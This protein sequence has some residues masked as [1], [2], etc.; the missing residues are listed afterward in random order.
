MSSRTLTT[1][2]GQNLERAGNPSGIHCVRGM[3]RR[4]KMQP[5]KC[6]R[7]GQIRLA[8]RPGA[9]LAGVDLKHHVPGKIELREVLQHP[10]SLLVTTSRYEM[11]IL[12]RPGPISEMDMPQ[13]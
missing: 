1:T 4:S 6:Q 11:L 7:L 12:D 5:R 9:A 8:L 13:A 3:N 10:P 2:S